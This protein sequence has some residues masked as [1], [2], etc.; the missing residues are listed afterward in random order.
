MRKYRAPLT[1][2]NFTDWPDLA[3]RVRYRVARVAAEREVSVPELRSFCRQVF[4]L[5]PK[6]WLAGLRDE[7]ARRLLEAGV[8]SEEVAERLGYTDA[9]HFCR[10]FKGRHG[11]CPHVWRARRRAELWEAIYNEDDWRETDGRRAAG[12][13]AGGRRCFSLERRASLGSNGET[14][15]R[16]EQ[17]SALPATPL[18]HAPSL[19]A[20]RFRLCT[21]LSRPIV[22]L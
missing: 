14:W 5:E 22:K 8:G 13:G 16:A 7:A 3:C 15:P 4:H 11:L 21:L 2:A 1:L 18:I 20:F 10:D 19:S 12:A 6:A 9:S 17:C